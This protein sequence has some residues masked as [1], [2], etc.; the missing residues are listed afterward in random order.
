MRWREGLR[1]SRARRG[2]V[3]LGSDDALFDTI[4]R[5]HREMLAT[6]LL[7]LGVKRQ[8]LD[9][10]MQE[11]LHGVHLGL[12]RFNPELG[13][14]RSWLIRIATHHFSHYR[15]RAHRRREVLWPPEG[16]EPLV[17]GAPSSEA[18]TM[19][20]DRREALDA[21]LAELR[22]ER[23]CVLVAHDILEMDMREIAQ[24]LAIP[25]NTAWS[26]LRLA[27]RDLEAADARRRARCRRRGWDEAPVVLP[28]FVEGG[29]RSSPLRDV[30]RDRIEDWLLRR[31]GDLGL[32]T[33]ASAGAWGASAL[34]IAKPLG[35]AAA[36]G[37][38]LAAGAALLP[39]HPAPARAQ[40]GIGMHA[41]I[42]GRAPA[43][44][45]RAPAITSAAPPAPGPHDDAAARAET[46]Q[47]AAA[48]VA[49]TASAAVR[50]GRE[51]LG[52]GGAGLAEEHRLVEEAAVALRAGHLAETAELLTRH[53]RRFPRGQLA[54]RR[55]ALLRELD[56][57]S[58]TR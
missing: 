57:G 28:A 50:H 15:D 34:G 47:S 41:A 36:A 54:G 44:A 46:E 27:R 9:D 18:L 29:Q 11:V 7:R 24:S 26:R 16:F 55:D 3:A 56:A 58:D 12:S 35:A 32:G 4:L 5:K 19:D 10:L 17:E 45:G 25:I 53:A 39:A 21:L 2:E 8:D 1:R 33:P 52:D 49:P 40:A 14:L 51:R 22:P 43:I 42:A 30:L 6:Y 13:T 23:R 20:S 38:V 48:P 37:A 31:L